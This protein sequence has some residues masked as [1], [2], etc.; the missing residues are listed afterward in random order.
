MR[1]SYR[2]SPLATKSAGSSAIAS[3]EPQS[4]LGSHLDHE[5]PPFFPQQPRERLEILL[6]DTDNPILFDSPS[7]LV[8]PKDTIAIDRVEARC[9]IGI[10]RR[11]GSGIGLDE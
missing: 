11:K 10:Q 8:A 3:L 2:P 7:G 6:R 5:P 1:L 9:P 4:R